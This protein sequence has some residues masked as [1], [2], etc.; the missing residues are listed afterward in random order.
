MIKFRSFD[1]FRIATKFSHFFVFNDR[2]I[3]VLFDERNT[4]YK[5]RSSFSHKKITIFIKELYA[6]EN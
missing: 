1:E 2:Y 5:Y 4:L 6:G 3:T